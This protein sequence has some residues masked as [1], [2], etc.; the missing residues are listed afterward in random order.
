MSLIIA[1]IGTSH[2]GDEKKAFSLID[3]AVDSGADAVKF[4]WV[5]ADEILHPLTGTVNLP[6][7]KISLYS[8]FR[9]LECPAEFYKKMKDYA[10]SKN[11]RFICSPFGLRSL[12]ELVEIEPDAVKIASPE[13]NHFLMLEALA[14]CNAG[15]RGRGKTPF[16]VILSSGVSTLSD[17]EKKQIIE[18]K[19]TG[20]KICAF[21]ITHYR[22]ADCKEEDLVEYGDYK[23]HKACLNAFLKIQSDAKK[24]NLNLIAFPISNIIYKNILILS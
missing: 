6:T 21:G 23:L 5:Y 2:E 18:G 10:H 8:R 22:F 19:Y 4:Q 11:V 17:I 16:P 7:G 24:E 20:D 9:Q 13:L 14:E 15:R 12:K 1:E 3:A